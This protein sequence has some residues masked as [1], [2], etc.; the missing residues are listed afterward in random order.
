MA[1]WKSYRACRAERSTVPPT[2]ISTTVHGALRGC[3]RVWASKEV[4]DIATANKD[5]AKSEMEHNV[6]LRQSEE[7]RSRFKAAAERVTGE[8]P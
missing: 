8:R 2:G 3:C 4:I 7:H 5:A 1:K 6:V